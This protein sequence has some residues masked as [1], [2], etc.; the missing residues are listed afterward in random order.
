[1]NVESKF[2]K[3]TVHYLWSDKKFSSSGILDE[4]LIE[5]MLGCRAQRRDEFVSHPYRI[6][7]LTVPFGTS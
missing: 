7:L 5:L 4:R 1:M 2:Q 3:Q 6:E